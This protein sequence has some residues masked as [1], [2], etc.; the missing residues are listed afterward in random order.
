[1]AL[2]VDLAKKTISLSPGAL[3]GGVTRRVG[4]DRGEGFERLWIGQA[5]HRRVLGEHLASVP[6]Y[7]V[8]KSIRL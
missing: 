5:V 8:E 1:M 3:L 6:G 2:S 4:F 7:E